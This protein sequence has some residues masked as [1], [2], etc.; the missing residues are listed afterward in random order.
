LS[1]YPAIVNYIKRM[2]ERPAFQKGIGGRN[3]D[4]CG[5]VFAALKN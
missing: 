4:T 3:W 2:S 5:S 1:A